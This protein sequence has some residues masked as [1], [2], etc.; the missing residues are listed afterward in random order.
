MKKIYRS[1]FGMILLFGSIATAK[2]QQSNLPTNTERTKVRPTHEQVKVVHGETSAIKPQ[3]AKP[4]VFSSREE[5]IAGVER[6]REALIQEIKE[7]SNN[8]EKALYLRESLWRLENAIVI[9]PSKN[10]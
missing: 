9:E 7:N 10:N 8:P 2:A 5:L 4:Y 6:K 3:D 1:V